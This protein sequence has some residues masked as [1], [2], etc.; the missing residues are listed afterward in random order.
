MSGMKFQTPAAASI[1]CAIAQP[2]DPARQM[3]ESSQ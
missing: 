3:L 1:A 2:G